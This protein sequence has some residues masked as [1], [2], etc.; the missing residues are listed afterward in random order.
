MQQ[1]EYI[2]DAVKGTEDI[3][4]VMDERGKLGWKVVGVL[5]KLLHN[6]VIFET[7]IYF[8]RKLP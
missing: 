6:N 4:E 2:E 8:M 1:Y 5:P 7:H 3:I